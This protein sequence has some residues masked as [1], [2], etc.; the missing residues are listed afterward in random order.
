[1]TPN[2][3]KAVSW[4]NDVRIPGLSEKELN[5]SQQKPNIDEGIYGGGK[6]FRPKEKMEMYK[7]QGRFPANLLVS[8]DMLND[9]LPSGNKWKKNYGAIDYK[10]LNY[11]SSTNQCK[12]GG[13]YTGTNTYA[14]SGSSSRYYDID[15]W[16]DKLLEDVE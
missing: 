15:K 11:Q 3:S 1:M 2:Y 13:G 6:G 9:G 7:P 5:W 10:G 16:F 8:D 4:I 14:D 12:H